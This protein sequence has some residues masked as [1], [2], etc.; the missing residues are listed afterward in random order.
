M[1]HKTIEPV[2]V[3]PAKRGSKRGWPAVSGQIESE[4]HIKLVA[5]GLAKRMAKTDLVAEAI[6]QYVAR[7]FDRRT[8]DDR[9]AA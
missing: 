8:G 3:Q 9:R 1:P 2:N 7:E 5:I 4:T 6:E